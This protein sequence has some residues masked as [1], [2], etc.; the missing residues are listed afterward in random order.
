MEIIQIVVI[1]FALFAISRIF[2]NIQS[3][4]ISKIESIFW[5]FLWLGIILIALFPDY[6]SNL[7]KVF[8]ISRG[9]DMVIY[10]GLVILAYLIFR[11]YA[12]LEG[13]D[14]K[15]TKIVRTIAIRKM[16]K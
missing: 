5:F 12:K 10:L 9:V 11:L 7:A 13:Q 4:N 8:G 16:K 3:K 6:L 2:I 1:L 14:K 15:I